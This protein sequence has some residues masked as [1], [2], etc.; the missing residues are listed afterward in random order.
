MINRFSRD[1]TLVRFPIGGGV[2]RQRLNAPHVTEDPH[3]CCKN[4][5]AQPGTT[6]PLTGN[7]QKQFFDFSGRNYNIEWQLSYYYALILLSPYPGV[8]D[9]PLMSAG[10]IL[11]VFSCDVS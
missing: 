7:E 5:F 10:F 2:I 8:P 11:S 6:F 9:N 1:N 3:P 4:V